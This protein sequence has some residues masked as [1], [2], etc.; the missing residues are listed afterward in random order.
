M[1]NATQIEALFCDY[2]DSNVR[3][4]ALLIN[5]EWGT[6]KTQ[7]TLTKLRPLAEAN[8]FKTAY[9]SVA[10]IES[11]DAFEAN[12]FLASY[13][14]LGKGPIKPIV[15]ASIKTVRYWGSKVGISV[16]ALAAAK[17]E[18][19]SKTVIFIDDL[20]RASA[21]LRKRILYRVAG[22]HELRNTRAIIL[23]D[24]AKIPTQDTDYNTI[25]E[26]TVAR[27]IEYLPTFK[28]VA[29]TAVKVVVA[30]TPKKAKE[31]KGWTLFAHL[32]EQTVSDILSAVLEN[33]KCRNL[34]SAITAIAESCELFEHLSSAR[35][36][37][38]SAIARSITH[39]CAA[40]VIELRAQRGRSPELRT[41]V[42]A[43]TDVH[44]FRILS[45]A[46]P[47]KDYLLEFDSK[48]G[49]GHDAEII[50]SSEILDYL[51]KGTCD[52]QRLLQDILSGRPLDKSIPAYRRLNKY[53]ALSAQDFS[54]LSGEAI[55][56]ISSLKIRSFQLIAESAQ[57]LFHLAE[58]GMLPVTP[59]ELRIRYVEC[60]NELTKEYQQGR[61]DI[62]LEYDSTM[63]FGTPEGEFRV[64][65]ENIQSKA[66][67]LEQERFKRAKIAEI[68]KLSSDPDSFVSCLNSVDSRIARSSCLET[69]DADRIG[70]ILENVLKTHNAPHVIV[71]KVARAITNRYLNK[72]LGISFDSEKSFLEQ[73]ISRTG[74][75]GGSPEDVLLKD[76]LSS[77]QEALNQ[78]I[79]SL[80]SAK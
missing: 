18:F 33:S 14:W 4:G 10:E 41:Y 23:A 50:K 70:N 39:S 55:N 35:S 59:I 11:L 20:E 69:E 73:L 44:W 19:S 27:T 52:F 64:V 36:G 68:E 46:N 7:L 5:G 2:L 6:G 80:S 40:F 77:L 32:D 62:Q 71:Y 38:D 9:L 75:L 31:P 17:N 26:K 8:G 28:D 21:E 42:S 16:D 63:L 58:K 74:F 13:H 24:E 48:Y 12:L 29:D 79:Q 53:R 30:A 56:E 67:L 47:S 78:S 22:L 37:L 49:Q 76:A 51:E 3:K 66:N 15:E 61:S 45:G 43:S 57:T 34:R 25:K 72:S 65:L 60:L 54:H 1:P